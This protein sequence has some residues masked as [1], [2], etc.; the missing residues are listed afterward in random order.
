MRPARCVALAALLAAML[1][2]AQ[3]VPAPEDFAGFRIRAYSA[4]AAY[5]LVL[6]L[7]VAELVRLWPISIRRLLVAMAAAFLGVVAL[8][9]AQVPVVSDLAKILFGALAGTAFVRTIERLW[10]LAPIGLLVPLADAWSV[11]SERGVTRAVIDRGQ[12]EPAWIT[13]PTIAVPVPGYPYEQFGQ[14]GIVDVL[15][16]AL[17]LGAATRW[18]LGVRRGIAAMWV[19]LMATSVLLF[20]AVDVAVPALPLL[21]IAFLVAYA[22]AIWRDAR[23]AWAEA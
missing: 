12:G 11:Y 23:S 8:N 7:L 6:V 14:L 2:L 15:F 10:W 13:W 5:Y 16:I 1:L 4:H 17:F 9:L 19:A 22:P 20:E 18:Q 21:C 3:A